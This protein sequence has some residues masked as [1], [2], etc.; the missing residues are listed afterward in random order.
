MKRAFTMIEL[1]F[2]IVVIGILAGVAIPKFAATRDDAIISKARAT[3]GAVR[4]ALSTEK[5]KRILR[6]DFNMT[7]ASATAGTFDVK[8]GTDTTAT[9]LLEYRVKVCPTSGSKRS[10]WEAGSGADLGKFT[11]YGP[12]GHTCTFEIDNGKF[13]KRNCS[14]SGMSDL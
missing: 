6:G 2:V 7:V 3:V 12:Q 5:Q 1:V 14:I 11:F 4:S 13:V 8:F 9:P 10:C